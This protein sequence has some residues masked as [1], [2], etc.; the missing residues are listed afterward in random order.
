MKWSGI[1]LDL[2]VYPGSIFTS[3]EK[4]AVGTT[5]GTFGTIDMI[6]LKFSSPGAAVRKSSS[7]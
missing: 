2:P 4:A 5:P 6:T 1:S 7:V 3:P